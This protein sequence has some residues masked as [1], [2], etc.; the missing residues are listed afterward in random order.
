MSGELTKWLITGSPF[1]RA[2]DALGE[3]KPPGQHV[4]IP[5]I[6]NGL[7]RLIEEVAVHNSDDHHW[8]SPRCNRGS[9]SLLFI[10]HTQ[11]LFSGYKAPDILAEEPPLPRC[12]SR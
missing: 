3:Q 4:S 2:G 11:Q 9:I 10:H 12:G 1:D 6:D 7:R 5:G 8:P